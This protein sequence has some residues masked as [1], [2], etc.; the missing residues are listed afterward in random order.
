MNELSTLNSLF[1]DLFGTGCAPVTL[2]TNAAA[3]RVDIKEE[4]DAYILEMELPGRSENDISIELDHNNLKIAS[5]KDEKEEKKDKNEKYIL[6]ERRFASFE[7]T[8]G[9]PQDVDAS[10]INASFKNGVLTVNM[11]KK[12]DSAPTKIAIEAA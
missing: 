1:D 7:R 12:P 2:G 8:F 10:T 3:P 4:K 9:L 5:V 6:K 11:L